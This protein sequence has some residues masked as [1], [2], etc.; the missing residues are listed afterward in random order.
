MPLRA[1]QSKV[2]AD[3]AVLMSHLTNTGRE[4]DN[5]LCAIINYQLIVSEKLFP[6][7][8]PNAKSRKTPTEHY[9]QSSRTTSVKLI[10]Q[11]LD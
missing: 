10:H 11:D 1:V 6:N 4:I 2:H 7:L 5:S 3:G 9:C 8:K